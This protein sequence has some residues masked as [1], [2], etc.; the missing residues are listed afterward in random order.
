MQSTATILYRA[1]A[2]RDAVDV[3]MRSTSLECAVAVR[4][5][6][7]IASGA[8]SDVIRLAGGKS[9]I[10]E[11]IDLP[12]ILILPGM[13]NAHTHLDLT[14][15]G[16]RPYKG[17]FIDW[18]SWI[19]ENAP[20]LGTDMRNDAAVMIGCHQSAASGAF[21]TG[22]ISRN[23]LA[24]EEWHTYEQTGVSFLECL[25]WGDEQAIAT[26][27]WNTYEQLCTTFQP[28]TIGIQPH[29]PYSTSK[30]IYEQIAKWPCRVS[31]H[32]AETKE[33]IQFTR[34]AAGPFAELLKKLGKWNDSIKPT[35]LHPIDYLGEDILK[36]ADDPHGGWL[37]AHCNYVEDDHIEKLAQWNAS[38]AYCPVAS[39]Y[40][41]HHQDGSCHRYQDMIEAGVNVCIGTDS[42]ICQPADEPQ[43][44]GVLPQVRHLYQRDKTDVDLLLTMATI[45]G[46]I[47]L[48]YQHQ[49]PTLQKGAPGNLV[50]VCFDANDKTAPLVQVLSGSE[51]AYSI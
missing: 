3:D 51:Q 15:A 43:P 48:G 39:D 2:L 24:T 18:I 19:I 23:C 8:E 33:E 40:F 6:V 42:I 49:L 34:D 36:R 32:L 26:K 12:D 17:D 1:A 4:Q 22:D 28:S 44:L 50:G 41:G 13:V 7:I 46:A 45:N 29:A 21:M 16:P 9:A 25:G 30:A 14:S 11:K 31:T 37:L 35:G 27:L 20:P 38:V 10:D 5:G 47:A